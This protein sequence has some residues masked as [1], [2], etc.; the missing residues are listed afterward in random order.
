MPDTLERPDTAPIVPGQPAP[1][2]W[3]SLVRLWNMLKAVIGDVGKLQTDLDDA[4]DSLQDAVDHIRNQ[5]GSLADLT[6]RVDDM[7]MPGTVWTVYCG[8]GGSDGKRPIPLGSAK[9]NEKWALCD[10][11]NGTPDLRGRVVVGAG[12]DFA[13]GDKGGASTH[14]HAVAGSVAPT[15]LD[16]NTVAYHYHS[17]S[18]TSLSDGDDR[19]FTGLQGDRHNMNPTTNAVGGSSGHTH[20]VIL[21]SAAASSMPPYLALHPVMRLPD[22]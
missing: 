3:E 5:G 19:Q 7:V 13:L 9:A 11:A 21:T 15:T 1:G 14:D 8:L 22:M 10:G 20:N 17:M 2:A 4:N 6:S 16:Q 18:G 12:G